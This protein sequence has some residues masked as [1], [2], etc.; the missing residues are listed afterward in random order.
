M[1]KKCVKV[2]VDCGTGTTESTGIFGIL[3]FLDEVPEDPPP[4]PDGEGGGGGKAKEGDKEDDKPKEGDEPKK[5]KTK[6]VWRRRRI[7]RTR[8]SG[9][10]SV[11][12]AL[13]ALLKK[14]GIEATVKCTPA[15]EKKGQKACQDC[16]VCAD[17]E[18]FDNSIEGQV[19]LT[20][21]TTTPDPPG[22][23]GGSSEESDDKDDKIIGP[24]GG[25]GGGIKRQQGQGVDDGVWLFD[26]QSGTPVPAG[27]YTSVGLQS[28]PSGEVE[29]HLVLDLLRPVPGRGVTRMMRREILLDPA[30]EGGVFEIAEDIVSKCRGL[31]IE[32]YLLSGS[33]VAFPLNQEGGSVASLSV[34]VAN[35]GPPGSWMSSGHW[36]LKEWE[37]GSRP[38][39][40]FAE[41][42]ELASV[43]PVPAFAH[44]RQQQSFSGTEELMFAGELE[45]AGKTLEVPSPVEAMLLPVRE[46][47]LDLQ[48]LTP[49]S[50]AAKEKLASCLNCHKGS[51]AFNSERSMQK[52]PGGSTVCC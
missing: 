48:G 1:A 28:P 12:N 19:T 17:V 26:P 23:S 27:R 35:I 25:A 40:A 10:R 31:G 47:V 38:D 16:E 42:P 30:V 18:D 45:F 29:A 33:T 9:P 49:V 46:P 32:A 41:P 51:V 15:T 52:R 21:F 7:V 20:E 4:T 22:G 43:A 14:Y 2:H 8:G 11:A 36:V 44:I 39:G 6:K 3:S 5:K 50:V 24:G 34:R 13:A 37:L